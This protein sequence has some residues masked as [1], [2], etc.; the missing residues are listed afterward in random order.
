MRPGSPTTT[1][2]TSHLEQLA[3][4]TE[5][6]FFRLRHALSIPRV[7]FSSLM[8]KG[9]FVV[10]SFIRLMA[11]ALVVAALMTA[12]ILAVHN[13]TTGR[14]LD[15]LD[16]LNL[17]LSLFAFRAVVAL[18]VFVNARKILFRLDDKDT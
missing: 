15:T 10:Y 4:T 1:A 2:C 11:Q 9:S 16:A 3:N 18:L 7:N 5:S 6:L 17:V 13:V 14:W 12:G 8:S